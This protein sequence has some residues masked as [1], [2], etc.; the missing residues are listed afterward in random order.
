MV[1]R[2]LKLARS[3]LG[4][5]EYPPNSNKV[6][7]NEA[8]GWGDI[9]WCLVFI[10]WLFRELGILHLFFDGEKCAYVPAFQDWARKNGLLV[11]E[12]RPGDLVCFDFN[13]NGQADH[14]GLCELYDGKYVTTID[15][16]T[17][18]GNEANGGAVMRRRRRKKYIVAV[19]RPRYEEREDEDMREFRVEDLTDEQVLQL[20]ERLNGVLK[21]KPPSDW[22]AE[23][24]EWAEENGIIN[25]DEH[26]RKQYKKFCTREEVVQILYNHEHQ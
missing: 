15:G 20:A 1:D 8:F 4:T 5:V 2:I 6:K 17:G 22:S 24:R 18:V 23:A 10:W 12:P 16:N 26:G 9:H 13:G 11:D 7:Y 21:E 25:G 14:I 19:I 3:Q